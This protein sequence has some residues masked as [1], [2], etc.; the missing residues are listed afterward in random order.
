MSRFSLQIP[1]EN[2][3]E[4]LNDINSRSSFRY[5]QTSI[6]EEDFYPH[7]GSR[8]RGKHQKR[9]IQPLHSN[10]KLKRVL[11]NKAM[12]HGSEHS[13]S[14]N[15]GYNDKT[16]EPGKIENI[17]CNLKDISEISEFQ[18]KRMGINPVQIPRPSLVGGN[19]SVN[20]YSD[21]TGLHYDLSEG[22]NLRQKAINLCKKFR[23]QNTKLEKAV[24][25]S[26]DGSSASASSSKTKLTPDPKGYM[27][28]KNNKLTPK[29]LKSD[30]RFR[31][32]KRRLLLL[33]TLSSMADTGQLAVPQH[34]RE[35]EN[36]ED[37]CSIFK[38]TCIPERKSAVD[39]VSRSSTKPQ[40]LN[41][42]N[43]KTE[44]S[45]QDNFD[46]LSASKSKKQ[47][48]G[49]II[50]VGQSRLQE[51][52]S[53]AS[54]HAKTSRRESCLS[55]NPMNIM[56]KSADFLG[57]NYLFGKRASNPLQ[58]IQGKYFE[59]VENKQT[60]SDK[61]LKRPGSVLYSNSRR[62]TAKPIAVSASALKRVSKDTPQSLNEIFDKTD[63]PDT[64]QIN[65]LTSI[66]K[67]S[68][69]GSGS[70]V[71]QIP[72]LVLSKRDSNKTRS[73]FSQQLSNAV[74]RY[75]G[76]LKEDGKTSRTSVQSHSRY[77]VGRALEGTTKVNEL[78]QKI[79]HKE[80]LE[81]THDSKQFS[82]EEQ[83]SLNN[84]NDKNLNSII[85]ASYN[86]I[87]ETSIADDTKSVLEK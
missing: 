74:L 55:S 75:R 11:A 61:K 72:S 42:T 47:S 23:E 36:I 8:T 14:N 57:T 65:S 16:D 40:Q 9:I 29:Q 54:T 38:I 59:N 31:Y 37:D 6:P 73:T 45:D 63:M 18:N 30:I 77:S 82:K 76:S 52:V 32:V 20:I 28:T 43:L 51:I 1:S 34:H 22:E 3:F 69:P 26:K 5:D 25:S 81:N 44:S 4:S 60:I 71:N 84:I 85:N 39:T 48:I 87:P 79:H 70:S 78:L 64:S 41:Q 58:E 13:I 7:H 21:A 27:N 83:S 12:R 46:Q 66:A 10:L 80:S 33:R 35:K 86:E 53:G 62:L 68:E 56:D 24:F 2:S 67:Q 49:S 15:K 50:G 17:I 19:L